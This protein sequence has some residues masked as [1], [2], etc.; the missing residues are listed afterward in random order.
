MLRRFL[1]ML[2]LAAAAGCSRQAPLYELV[3]PQ[4]D[5]IRIDL[6]RLRDGKAHFFTY[7]HKGKNVNFFVR[8][9]G[10]KTLRAHF[11]ACY[12]CYKYKRG[13][14]Q[15][16]NQVVCIACRIGYDLETPVW[17]FVGACVP[18]TLKCRVEDSS[19]ALPLAAIEKG[20][21]F[22]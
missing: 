15:E 8:T 21:R 16:G 13:Y 2:C 14:F 5:A 6:E 7:R 1:A 19:L 10:E 9:D 18:I 11:D 4:Q 12:S 17:E 3:T 20:E 22:F